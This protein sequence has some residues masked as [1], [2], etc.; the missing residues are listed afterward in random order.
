MSELM[1][2]LNAG[3]IVELPSSMHVSATFIVVAVFSTLCF[4]SL[5]CPET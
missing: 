5:I 3:W 4:L 2:V 1:N